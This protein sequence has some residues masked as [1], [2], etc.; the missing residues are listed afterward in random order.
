M[1]YIDINQS[2]VYMCSRSWALLPPP[3][4]THPSGS[5]QCTSPE[6]PVSCIE[7]GLVVCFTYDNVHVSMLFSSHPCL[8]P[9]SWEVIFIPSSSP[10]LRHPRLDPFYLI[11]LQYVC[12]L[13]LSH[14]QLFCDLM[15]CSPPGS[16]VHGILQARILDW[17]A[18]FFSRGSS[19]PRDWTPVSCTLGGIFT[20][21][22]TREACLLQ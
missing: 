13:S 18:I 5:S 20:G 11:L 3:S 16:S 22:A 12:A 15:H 14:V 4:S 19:Q 8:L 17:V 6:H 21:W 1:P 7:P 2:W 10:S 9:Q